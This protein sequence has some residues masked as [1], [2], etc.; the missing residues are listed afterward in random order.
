MTPKEYRKEIRENLKNLNLIGRSL[1]DEEIQRFH[2]RIYNVYWDFEGKHHHP[3]LPEIK[4]VHNDPS[5][6]P[7]IKKA[8]KSLL[9]EW[10][11]N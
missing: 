5:V 11:T 1:S 2:T 4:T 10:K 8:A 9:R 7:K 3:Y 6:T